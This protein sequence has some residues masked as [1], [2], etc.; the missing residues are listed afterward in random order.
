MTEFPSLLGQTLSHY[1]ILS[2]IGDGGMGVVYAA[3]DTRLRRAVALKFLPENVA[4]DPQALVRFHREAE[5]ASSLNHPHICTI[6]DVGAADGKAFIVME[7]LEGATLRHWIQ[8]RPLSV[9]QILDFAT[10]IADALDAAHAKGIIHRDIKPANIFVTDRE[11]IKILDFGLAKAADDHPQIASEATADF[12]TAPGIAVGTAAY[13][14][15]EQIRGEPLDTRSDLFSFG[16]VLYEMATGQLPFP[17]ATSGMVFD[18]IL[19]RPPVPASQLRPELPP[20]LE[21]IINKSLEKDK[22]L[23]YQ[24]A[25]ELRGD[26]R[27]LKRDS[28]SGRTIAQS[29]AAVSAIPDAGSQRRVNRLALFAGVIIVGAALAAVWLVRAR[30]TYESLTQRDTIV[31]TDFINKTGDP[32]FDDALK[33]ALASGLEQSP[34][35]NILSGRRVESTLKLM[36]LSSDERVTRQIADDVCQR[37]GSKAVLTSA[38]SSIGSSYLIALDTT[39]CLTGESIAKAD[40]QVSRKEDVLKGLNKAASALRA[41]LGESL[42]SIEKYDVPLDQV[43]TSSLEALKAFSTGRRIVDTK[44]DLDAIPFFKSAIQDDPNFA[45]GYLALGSSYANIAD[46]AAASENIRKAFDL[47]NNVSEREKLVI[48]GLYYATV[49]GQ[50]PDAIQTYNLL[51]QT[52]PAE[53]VPHIDLG[54]CYSYLGRFQESLDQS[55]EAMRLDPDSG[56]AFANLT[57][58]YL[59]LGRLEEA[60]ANIRGAVERKLDSPYLHIH[61]YQVAFLQDNIDEMENQIIWS[62]QNPYTESV[63]QGLEGWTAAYQGRIAASRERFRTAIETAKRGG[64]PGTAALLES[65]SAWTESELGGQPSSSIQQA[66]SSI[67]AGGPAFRTRAYALMAFSKLGDV[68]GA[69]QTL[70]T[71]RKDHPLD[72]LANSYW[73]PISNALWQIH[74]GNAQ[75][76]FNALE[77]VH[78]MDLADPAWSGGYMPYVRGHALLLANKPATAEIEFQKL[79]DHPGVVIN[80]P[81]GALAR[82]GSARSYARA[83]EKEKSREAY[84]N[85]LE[86]WKGA[87]PNFPLLLQARAEYARLK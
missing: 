52:Y 39:D 62:R 33:P 55:L 8:S 64:L 32:V 80:C 58:S 38:I 7:L 31:L 75:A 77:S 85:L 43:T 68:R 65:I 51:I 73:I 20:R 87:D 19:N 74:R 48:A 44:G 45:L 25:S 29:S 1:R 34:F 13:M 53:S 11:Q 15:P 16:I 18:G 63:F 42:S 81:T 59:D 21:E 86:L 50:L 83:G 49:T 9:D 60:K 66:H 2:K 40:A 12:V 78:A 24:H 47:R 36:G 57:S 82:L 23:R 3:E 4:A 6:H 71:L 14:S 35:L 70:D 22:A 26:L 30:H 61:A 72:T 17:G 67:A 79:I 28:D 54:L 56:I 10:Q 69:S 46:N 27:R 5:S 37:T 76:A 84:E 41:K